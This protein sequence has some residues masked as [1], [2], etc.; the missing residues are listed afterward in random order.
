MPPASIICPCGSASTPA[1]CTTSASAPTSATCC[2]S[3]RASISETEYV[4]LCRPRRTCRRSQSL[5][6]E[7]PRGRRDRRQL[8]A[9]RAD[10][11]PAGAAARRRRRCSTRRTTC[12]RRSS[13]CRS[14]V[15]IHD[16]IHLMFPQYLPNR[17]ALRLRARVDCAWR[18]GAPTRVLTVSES[19]KR[20]IL[21]FVDIDAGEDRR[22]LQRLSTSA[23]ASSRARRTSCAS[24]S[25]T[26]S[27]TSSCST[28][29]TSSRTRT[30]SG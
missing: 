11:D 16:C 1:S 8:L 13:R 20:D 28:P 12:C 21:R 17:L 23:S 24:A 26:S 4:L 27:T 5:G 14:V 22:H 9:R 6:D 10:P 15:T 30:S 19:S 18:R 3:S 25:A 2:G 7:L 29:A